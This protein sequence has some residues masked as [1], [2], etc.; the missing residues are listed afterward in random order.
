M[1]GSRLARYRPYYLLKRHL[2]ED[3]PIDGDK[4]ARAVMRRMGL[5]AEFGAPSEAVCFRD[6]QDNR[7]RAIS[8]FYPVV[9]QIVDLHINRHVSH[10]RIYRQSDG[11]LLPR[12]IQPRICG[13][14][15]NLRSEDF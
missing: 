15:R 8:A 12:T 10:A 3:F 2:R 7:V 11:I 6:P 13:N 5:P 4:G 14:A 9:G 1:S